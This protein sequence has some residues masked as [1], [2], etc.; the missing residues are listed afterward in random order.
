MNLQIETLE[1]AIKKTLDLIAER[2]A[3]M[4]KDSEGQICITFPSPLNESPQFVVSVNSYFL[5]G[6]DLTY[7]WSAKTLKGAL[8]KALHGVNSWYQFEKDADC[9]HPLSDD[10][11]IQEYM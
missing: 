9:F 8:Q 1:R 5:K 2:E 7:V 4:C 6:S 10:R 3:I 11:L